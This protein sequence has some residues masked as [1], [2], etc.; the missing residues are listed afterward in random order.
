[1]YKILSQKYELCNKSLFKKEKKLCSQQQNKWYPKKFL[2]A[3]FEAT[4]YFSLSKFT[5]T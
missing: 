1:M 5:C 3:H 2:L 4:F